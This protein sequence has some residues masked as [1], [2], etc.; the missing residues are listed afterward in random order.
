MEKLA[1]TKQI[2]QKSIAL[3]AYIRFL[4][5][6]DVIDVTGGWKKLD[7][8]EEALLNK[9]FLMTT[10]QNEPILVGDLISISTL[11][12]QATLHGRVKS[13]ERKGLI[14]L[15]ADQDDARKKHVYPTQLAMKRYEMLSDNFERALG[16][17]E[18]AY[19]N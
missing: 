18:Q 9:L 14:N 1:K 16:S 15:I 2:L 8:L 13:L 10:I 6:I 19:A 4:N 7:P 3:S 12:S 5:S 11:G 17:A